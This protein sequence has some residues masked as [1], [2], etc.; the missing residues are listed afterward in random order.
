MSKTLYMMGVLLAWASA[1]AAGEMPLVY[2]KEDT[3][4]DCA[5]PA[6]PSFDDL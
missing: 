3:G 5:K 1:L 4:K 6:L 2:D